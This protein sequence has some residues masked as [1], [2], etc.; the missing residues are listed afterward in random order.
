M[1][2]Q[3]FVS[4]CESIAKQSEK[5]RQMLHEKTTEVSDITKEIVESKK[6]IKECADITKFVLETKAAKE[7]LDVEVIRAKQQLAREM[8]RE[9]RLEQIMEKFVESA[10]RGISDKDER[11]MYETRLKLHCL[12]KI[13]GITL[14]MDAIE[15]TGNIS[16][17]MSNPS[18][19]KIQPFGWAK[20]EKTDKEATKFLWDMKAKLDPEGY[21][22][23]KQKGFFGDGE[24]AMEL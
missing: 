17:W 9:E 18:G 1:E 21:E 11:I 20:G 2:F 10:Q 5:L 19:S 15:A 24:E 6:I 23:L 12:R 14:D 3:E 4:Q 13:S 7:R 16:G 22:I 8:K